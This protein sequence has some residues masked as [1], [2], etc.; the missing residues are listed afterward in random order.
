MY[1]LSCSACG[2]TVEIAPD[3]ALCSACGEDLI[4][5]IPKEGTPKHYYARA[6]QYID[7]DNTEQA[8]AVVQDGLEHV[9]SSDLLLLG[10]IL[11]EKMGQY[12][13]MRHYVSRIP[14][15]DSLRAEGE[16]LLRAHQARQRAQ[17]QGRDPSQAILE[18]MSET[19]GLP[20]EA[21]YDD[22]A[23][24]DWINSQEA[25][26]LV[27][28]GG[29]TRAVLSILVIAGL[30]SA[31]WF[32]RGQ[33]LSQP[34]IPTAFRTTPTLE[35]MSPDV[36]HAQSPDGTENSD[37][38]ANLSERDNLN[39]SSVENSNDTLIENSQTVGS[40]LNLDKVPQDSTENA[41]S[42]PTLAPTPADPLPTPT[43]AA[44][45]LLRQFQSPSPTDENDE[46]QNL[47]EPSQLEPSPDS[48]VNPEEAIPDD[49]AELA[50]P[51]PIADADPQNVVGSLVQE[52]FDVLMFLREAGFSDL[53]RLPLDAQL[54]DG[55]LVVTGVVKWYE[56]R[57]AIIEALQFAPGVEE[58]NAI[59]LITRTPETYTVQ[60]ADTLWI[61]A[62]R[63]FGDG[64]RWPQIY[65]LNQDTLLSPDTLGL[66]QVLKLPPQ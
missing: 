43:I 45:V 26:R 12:D 4:G 41:P 10:A 56:E 13:L 21:N 65:E 48:P 25:N 2:Q 40:E 53:A 51:E 66:G 15:D 52:P 24:N 63:I 44:D 54:N 1:K 46:T 29:A 23:A 17:R 11:A 38:A 37:S 50:T 55:K 57:E 30:V 9:I 64:A 36:I 3:A 39:D 47:E 19:F 5:L 14:V 59:Q 49:L 34:W 58:V 32:F 60:E 28:L 22:T 42:E 31:G 8:L 62:F 6:E 33:L 20:P 16:W 27:G 35:V 18:E 61:I 7:Q